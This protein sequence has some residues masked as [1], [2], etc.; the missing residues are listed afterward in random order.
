MNDEEVWFNEFNCFGNVIWM[1][2]EGKCGKKKEGKC[3]TKKE[4]K[5]GKKKEPKKAMKCGVG[6]CG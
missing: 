6:K 1:K 5:C 3:G 4:G 2:M